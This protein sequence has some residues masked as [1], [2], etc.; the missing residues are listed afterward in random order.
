[1][2]AVTAGGELHMGNYCTT[3]S[4]L[5]FINRLPAMI[6]ILRNKQICMNR[7]FIMSTAHMS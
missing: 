7:A 3:Q 2:P 6:Y 1:M 5:S 4:Q